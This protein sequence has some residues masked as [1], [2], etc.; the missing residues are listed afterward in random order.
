MMLN[1]YERILLILILL[2]K[3]DGGANVEKQCDGWYDTVIDGV[4]TRTV[5]KM[6]NASGVQLGLLSILR[7]L[8]EE[9][10]WTVHY[11]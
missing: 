11:S 4:L 10:G 2:N 6:Q 7:A 1:L 3:S 8:S 9:S 5:Q